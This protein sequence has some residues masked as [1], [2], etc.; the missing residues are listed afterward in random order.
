MHVHFNCVKGS[1]RYLERIFFSD[2]QSRHA[3]ASRSTTSPSLHTAR[4]NFLSIDGGENAVESTQRRRSPIQTSNAA[5][6]V[7]DD[8]DSQLES[9]R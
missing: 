1:L 6:I 9:P 2:Q 3:E 8:R 4:H 7:N 5:R